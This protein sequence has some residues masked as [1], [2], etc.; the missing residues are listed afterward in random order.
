MLRREADGDE[1]HRPK[2]G[3]KLQKL[4][5][6]VLVEG[7]DPARSEA[8]RLRSQEEILN[9]RRHVH[10]TVQPHASIPIPG[11]DSVVGAANDDQGAWTMKS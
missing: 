2:I 1:S 11:S 7:T 4:L 3:G 10:Q 6:V 8:L 5:H 9:A